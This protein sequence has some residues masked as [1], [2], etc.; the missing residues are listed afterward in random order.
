MDFSK[1]IEIGLIP[2]RSTVSDNLYLDFFT[3]APL[4]LAF[5]ALTGFFFFV[6]MVI[7][8]SLGKEDTA[9]IPN[10]KRCNQLFSYPA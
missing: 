5:L 3:F 4:A 7:L 1:R 9:L 2:G 10:R 6:A 8:P